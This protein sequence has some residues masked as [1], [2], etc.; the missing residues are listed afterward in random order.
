MLS[1]ERKTFVDGT[2]V[3]FL[4]HS[5]RQLRTKRGRLSDTGNIE[6]LPSLGHPNGISYFQSPVGWDKNFNSS[7]DRSLD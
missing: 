7:S 4:I 3:G 2:V 6:P 5:Y 1:R